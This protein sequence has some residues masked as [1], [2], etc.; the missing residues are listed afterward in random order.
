MAGPYY[1]NQPL[2]PGNSKRAVADGGDS[3]LDRILKG[4]SKPR[5]RRV[6]YCLAEEEPQEIDELAAAVAELELGCQPSSEQRKSVMIAIY[7]N[8]LPK[9]ADLRLVEFDARSKTV[10]LRQAPQEL[11][12]FL[13]LCK[14]LDAQRV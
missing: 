3:L 6:L 5:S 4:L 10:C 7:H 8:D 2:F 14:Q 12:D 11:Y 9:L 1:S 13:H